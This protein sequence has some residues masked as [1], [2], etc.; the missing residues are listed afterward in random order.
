MD[1]YALNMMS[2]TSVDIHISLLHASMV[3]L[4]QT[5]FLSF[6]V[7]WSMHVGYCGPYLQLTLGLSLEPDIMTL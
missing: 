3:A 1:P 2:G 7:L 6:I 4:M 5:P